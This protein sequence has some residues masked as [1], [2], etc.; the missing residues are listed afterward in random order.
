MSLSNGSDITAADKKSHSDFKIKIITT[1]M[2]K[3]YLRN[4]KT[5]LNLFQKPNGNKFSSRKE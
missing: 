4:G 5:K 3:L 1:A 2:N